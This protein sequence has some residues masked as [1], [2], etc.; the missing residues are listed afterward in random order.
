MMDSNAIASCPLALSRKSGGG[1]A[2]GNSMGLILE[3]RSSIHMSFS[4]LLLGNGI[5]VLSMGDCCRSLLGRTSQ[6]QARTV[7]VMI[8]QS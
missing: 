4:G 1:W 7:Q 6:A 2:R 5:S 3:A 8:Y